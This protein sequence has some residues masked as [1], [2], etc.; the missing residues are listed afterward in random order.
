MHEMSLALEICDITGRHVGSDERSQI[1]EV[2][3]EVGDAAGVEADSLRF[4]LEVL[5][6]DAPFGRA[7]PVIIRVP[8]DVLRVSYLE[9]DDGSADE[10]E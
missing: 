3:V 7:K 5:L 2:G 8:G 9:V 4:W 10:A 1:L 6:A